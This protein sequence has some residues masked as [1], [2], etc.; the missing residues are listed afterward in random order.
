MLVIQ[1]PQELQCLSTLLTQ[2]LSFKALLKP[3]WKHSLLCHNVLS[4]GNHAKIIKYTSTF[5]LP[6]ISKGTVGVKFIFFFACF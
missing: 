3:A 6:F 2:L 4:I 1:S 5:A